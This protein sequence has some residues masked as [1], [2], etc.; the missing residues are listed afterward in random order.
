M[1]EPLSLA[2][3]L[4]VV[5][6]ANF[7]AASAGGASILILPAMFLIGIPPMVA[8]GTNRFHRVFSTGAMLFKFLKEIKLEKKGTLGFIIVTIIGA[9]IG[10]VITVNLSPD[11]LKNIVLTAISIVIVFMLV[12]NNL[13]LEERKINPSKTNKIFT[14]VGVFL[15]SLY[16]A[17]I[18]SAAGTFLRLH[19]VAFCGYDFLKSAALAS[20]LGFTSSVVATI[21]FMGFGIIDYVLGVEMLVVGMAGGYLGA[22]FAIK[23]GNKFI[24]KIFFGVAIL[25]IIKL[26]VFG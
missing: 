5:F 20:V 4:A 21:L 14:I 18:G 7:Y 10:A 25:M 19:L 16:R 6:I 23:N 11:F 3:L 8:V 26:V 17:I 1:I 2:F 24:Q 9:I 22:T 15:V 12:K 13:G